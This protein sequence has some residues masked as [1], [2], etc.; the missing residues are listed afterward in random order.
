MTF[1]TFEDWWKWIKA[2]H[3]A[4]E[5]D[6]IIARAGWSAGQKALNDARPEEAKGLTPLERYGAVVLDAHREEIGDLDGGFLQDQAEACGLLHYVDANEPCEGY[7][8][9]AEYDPAFP[10]RCLRIKPEIKERME[11]DLRSPQS[12][13][14]AEQQ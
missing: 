8:R 1:T 13:H 9:C 4:S 7:C 6:F 11:I 12:Q 2:E 14:D 5:D 10:Q 3:G